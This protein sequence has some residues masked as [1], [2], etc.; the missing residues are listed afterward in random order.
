MHQRLMDFLADPHD[1]GPLSL[2]TFEGRDD[3]T[4]DG[5]LLNER[6]GQWYVIEDGIPTLFVDDLRPDDSHFVRRYQ[7]RLR[8]LGCDFKVSASEKSVDF[9]RIQSERLARDDQAE[10][11]DAMISM[12]M[13]ALVEIPTYK[14]ALQSETGSVLLEA[15]CGTGRLT[16]VFAQIAPE[17]VAVDM[18]RES[19]V[20]NRV[21]HHARTY[22]PVH[23]VHADLTHLP[24]QDGVFGRC[25]HAGVYEHIPSQALR[26][27]FLSH[28]RRT[29]KPGGT[30]MLSA[31]RYGGVT[32]LF[33]K[34]G[35]HD[36]GIPFFRFTPDELKSEVESAFK[37]EKF[38]SNLGI[39]MSM[40]IARA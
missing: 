8:A 1:G 29:M 22:N 27:Q 32:K 13:L 3:Q 12:K 39:Y 34:E 7:N 26:L 14:R 33:E 20:R 16:H 6:T 9:A 37:V 28:A 15:G 40:V 31:Y 24:L 21:R 25:A 18:S 38:I 36:G 4:R 17:V 5:I 19:L 23:Y 10:D 35:E 30:L 11:Y 2:H